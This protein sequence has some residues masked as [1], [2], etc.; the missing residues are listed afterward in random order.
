MGIEHGD[1]TNA[2]ARNGAPG[3]LQDADQ[4]LARTGAMRFVEP[5]REDTQLRAAPDEAHAVGPQVH[6]AL[7]L[8]LLGLGESIEAV[9]RAAAPQVARG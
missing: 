5:L 3:I 1:L 2:Q 7:D 8:R 9:E 4:I 6:D